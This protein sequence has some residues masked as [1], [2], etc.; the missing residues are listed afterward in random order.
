[1]SVGRVWGRINGAIAS[2]ESITTQGPTKRG[3]RTISILTLFN[4]C[5]V[6]MVFLWHVY[7]IRTDADYTL[8]VVKECIFFFL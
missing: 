1:M 8:D 3:S 7:G 4:D 6:E 5:L 2:A